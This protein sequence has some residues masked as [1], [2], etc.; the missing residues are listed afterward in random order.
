MR[1]V[2]ACVDI[3]I[4][5]DAHLH[6]C[7]YVHA[8]TYVHAWMYA[9]ACVCSDGHLHMH[10]CICDSAGMV[11]IYCTHQCTIHAYTCIHMH[12][13]AYATLRGWWR[14]TH[15]CRV[16]SLSPRGSSRRYLRMC[17]CAYVRCAH[18]HVCRVSSLS[19]LED[20]HDATCATHTHNT[21]VSAGV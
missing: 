3:C 14:C 21:H 19:G 18:V 20:R 8:W 11:A 6:T 2:C 4:Y 7:A 10:T 5:C 16:S 1:A 9:Y 13:P 15:G 17:M 12:P